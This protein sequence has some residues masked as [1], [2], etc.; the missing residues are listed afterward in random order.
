M[1]KN[2]IIITGAAG[3]IG[4]HLSKKLLENNYKIIGLDNLNNYYDVNLK[5]ERIFFLKKK[6]KN[7]HFTKLDI[8]NFDRLINLFKK[9]KIKTVIH[10][11]AQA[12]VRYSLENP[13]QYLNSNLIGFF[14]ILEAVKMFKVKNFL[15]A[16]TSS[17]YGNSLKSSLSENDTTD[18]PIQF[19]AATK[20]SNEVM[21]FSYSQVFKIKITCLRFFTVYGPWGR[22]D[23]SY[24]KFTNLMKKKKYIEVFNNGNH[25]RS[26]T[27]ID[28]I[29]EAILKIMHKREKS[30]KNYECFNLGNNKSISLMKFIKILENCLGI[31]A[32]IKFLPLQKG[33][34]KTTKANVKKIKTILKTF[35]KYN[36]K[37]G[38]QKFVDWYNDFYNNVK[39]YKK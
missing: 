27:Y 3:F 20:K 36:L 33:D 17:V 28:D 9:S 32:K 1:S 29:T 18:S 22:P 34:V 38:L 12:G 13:K 8:T 19:Y 5:K 37:Y 21:A 25:N 23:M 6:Y 39:K 35:P 16:S 14:N 31:K 30:N 26:F 10:L 2:T 15:F 11:A 4:F 24:F 7:F